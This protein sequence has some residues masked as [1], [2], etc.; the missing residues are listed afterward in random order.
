MHFGTYFHQKIL[1][2][3]LFYVPLQSI[4][5][6]RSSVGLEQRPSKAWVLGSNPNGITFQFLEIHISWILRDFTF[7]MSGI[8]VRFMK[9]YILFIS[10]NQK[11]TL[12]LQ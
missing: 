6:F 4:W 8:H 10:P 1:Y 7:K 12:L 5:R 11:I 9:K 2:K 3:K